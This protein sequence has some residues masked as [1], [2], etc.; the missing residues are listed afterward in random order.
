MRRQ[1]LFRWQYLHYESSSSDFNNFGVGDCSR[2]ERIAQ[3]AENSGTFESRQNFLHAGLM[4]CRGGGCRRGGAC[5]K[6]LQ[7]AV[8]RVML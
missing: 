4:R 1:L 8:Q 3:A 7:F 5:R 6:M 2:H